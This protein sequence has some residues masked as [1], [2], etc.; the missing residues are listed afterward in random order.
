[1]STMEH[2]KDNDRTYFTT[3]TSFNILHI[4]LD[5]ES[6]IFQNLVLQVIYEQKKN[7]DTGNKQAMHKTENYLVKLLEHVNVSPSFPSVHLHASNRC[8]TGDMENFLQ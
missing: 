6:F 5:I 3:K 1:M 8:K 7:Q 4:L 2:K